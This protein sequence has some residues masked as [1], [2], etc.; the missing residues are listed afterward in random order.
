MVTPRYAD[1]SDIQGSGEALCPSL[2]DPCSLVQPDS[3]IICCSTEPLG[4]ATESERSILFYEY[5]SGNQALPK[6]S[7]L[8]L[9]NSYTLHFINPII[10]PEMHA[11]LSSPG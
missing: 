5:G 8:H 4:T 11:E 3:I 2:R 10:G 6:Q 9:R 7:Q 1:I